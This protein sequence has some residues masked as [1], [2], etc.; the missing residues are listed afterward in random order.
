LSDVVSVRVV[1]VHES[2]DDPQARRPFPGGDKGARGSGQDIY[3][4]PG[5]HENEGSSRKQ[6]Q[7]EKQDTSHDDS[8]HSSR[9]RGDPKK[10]GSGHHN[11]NSAEAKR[12]SCLMFGQPLLNGCTVR[13]VRGRFFSRPES[14]CS[15]GTALAALQSENRP[16]CSRH[17][18]R[19]SVGVRPR[20]GRGLFECHRCGIWTYGGEFTWG[21]RTSLK[22][23]LAKS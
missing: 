16:P 21:A 13:Y 17:V 15:P 4:P 7:R 6:R 18:V 19:R 2:V 20:L 23:C 9:P 12:S 14:G 10:R 8:E 3:D 11:S 5:G 1:S 22:P